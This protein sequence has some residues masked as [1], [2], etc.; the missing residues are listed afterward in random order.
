M[1]MILN[2]V[3]VKKKKNV[4]GKI[5]GGN[6]GQENDGYGIK[7]QAYTVSFMCFIISL[8]FRNHPTR[9]VVIPIF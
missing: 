2:D 1:Y 3:L 7:C 9:A 4:I 8:H 5:G 6:P